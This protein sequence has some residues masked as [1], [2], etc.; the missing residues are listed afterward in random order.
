MKPQMVSMQTSL[1][2]VEASLLEEDKLVHLHVQRERGDPWHGRGP[3]DG[4]VDTIGEVGA[5]RLHERAQMVCSQA[6]TWVRRNIRAK[7]SSVR[8]F[9]S[10]PERLVLQ[11]FGNG[12]FSKRLES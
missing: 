9:S 11:C 5:Q 10:H 12:S 7:N 1:D 6:F 8:K 2:G 3:C 4:E